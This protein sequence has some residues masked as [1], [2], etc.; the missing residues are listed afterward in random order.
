MLTSRGFGLILTAALLIMPSGKLNA[1]VIFSNTLTN[2]WW[3][4]MH[5]RIWFRDRFGAARCFC[6][7]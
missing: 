5:K 3:P 1:S 6:R 7:S 2:G 4:G